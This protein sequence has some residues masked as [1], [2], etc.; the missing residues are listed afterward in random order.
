MLAL[1]YPHAGA[2]HQAYDVAA[3]GSRVLSFQPVITAAAGSGL[4][5]PEPPV[6]GL[7]VVMQ[8]TPKVAK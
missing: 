2:D 8:W 4:I 3:D 1:R 6:P 7:T 5:S